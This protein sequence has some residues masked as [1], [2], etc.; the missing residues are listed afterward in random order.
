MEVRFITFNYLNSIK[1]VNCHFSNKN[2]GLLNFSTIFSSL[3]FIIGIVVF[4]PIII[5]GFIHMTIKKVMTIAGSDTE[6]G[7]WESKQI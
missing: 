4:S 7:C 3:F 6:R 1:T 5:G 2:Q